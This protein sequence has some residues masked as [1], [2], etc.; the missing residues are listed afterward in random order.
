MEV[1]VEDQNTIEE[2]YSSLIQK[3]LYAAENNIPKTTTGI[4]R[5]P[6]VPWWN[7]ECQKQERIT[8][9]EYKKLRKDPNNKNK[10]RSFQRRRAIKQREFRRARKDS[11]HKYI[12]SL[13]ARTPTKKVWERLKKI[14]RNYTP[15]PISPL[16]SGGR[17]ITQPK[18]IAETFVEYY[19]EISQNTQK[20]KQ[21]SI[22]WTC[23]TESGW[24]EKFPTVGKWQ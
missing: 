12:N 13:N 1:E 22:Y 5:R 15:R 7:K 11:W 6:T 14:N 17:T 24:K 19:K 16:E 23:I 3:I 18:E 2:A 9:A 10:I 21:R 4:E 8:R 20:R